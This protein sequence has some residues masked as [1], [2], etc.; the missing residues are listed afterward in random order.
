MITLIF[1]DLILTAS[2][3][4]S[5]RIWDASN[6]SC[7]AIA[8]EHTDAIGCV[9]VSN[10]RKN[11]GSSFFVSGGADKVLKLWHVSHQRLKESEDSGT[12][13]SLGSFCSV[14]AHNKD[15]NSVDVSPNDALIA[16]GS[17]DSAIRLWNTSDLTS[18]GELSGH[19]RGVWCV[20][21]S[22]VD[23]CL[24]SAAGDRTVKIWS[25]VD[26]SCL[27]TMQGHTSS[28]LSLQFVHNGMQLVS[29]A[30]DGLI[31]VWNVRDGECQSI[32]DHHSE[33]VWA[34]RELD[35]EVI[36]AG[37]DA[38]LVKWRDVTSENDI[39]RRESEER[40]IVLEQELSNAFGKKRFGE[41]IFPLLHICK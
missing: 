24:A 5:C 7:I 29:G 27:R 32:L 1:R 36:S 17:Q 15:I 23:K 30:A 25:L 9:C 38:L 19:K 14:R 20:R 40:I 16:S 11:S 22:P 37:S 4:K 18:V 33:K 26:L 8:A 39:F 6:L 31:R 12:I 28:V 3:D 35:G 21:F 10:T 41:V 34:L 13:L 2:K